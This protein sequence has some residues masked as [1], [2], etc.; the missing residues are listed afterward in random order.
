MLTHR[1][2]DLMRFITERMAQNGVAPSHDEIAQEMGLKSKSSAH[3][4]LE[5]LRDRG[6]VVIFVA[7]QHGHK[8]NIIAEVAVTHTTSHWFLRLLILLWT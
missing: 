3:R 2:M 1:Q 4:L 7:H 8:V 6:G 5:R